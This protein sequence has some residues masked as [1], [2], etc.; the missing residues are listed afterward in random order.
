MNL[1]HHT[2]VRFRKVIGM[3]WF[4]FETCKFPNREKVIDFTFQMSEYDVCWILRHYRFYPEDIKVIRDVNGCSKGY[5]F[6]DFRSEL[7]AKRLLAQVGDLVKLLWS[8][9][10]FNMYFKMWYSQIRKGYCLIFI[11]TL[12]AQFYTLS[13]CLFHLILLSL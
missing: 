1:K 5:C 12:N 4:P 8:C 6:V 2:L 11:K 9:L 7:E 10:V 13:I 3:A